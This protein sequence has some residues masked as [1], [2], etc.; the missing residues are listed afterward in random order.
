MND[1]LV[2]N[3][4]EELAELIINKGNPLVN[5][6]PETT[7]DDGTVSVIL[8]TEE[9][10]KTTENLNNEANKKEIAEVQEP[11]KKTRAKIS[12]AKK[13]LTKTQKLRRSRKNTPGPS[14]GKRRVTAAEKMHVFE[15]ILAGK[16]GYKMAEEL[17]RSE[18]TIGKIIEELREF[19][20]A[21]MVADD[22][23][24]DGYVTCINYENT[25]GF[26][27]VVTKLSQTGLSRDIAAK[28]AQKVLNSAGANN[29][30]VVSE[31]ELFRVAKNTVSGT[32]IFTSKTDGGQSVAIMN[33][34][35]SERGDLA[36]RKKPSSDIKDHIDNNRIFK[37]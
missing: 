33:K 21:A 37:I 19:A 13:P 5:Q 35:A 18:P 9:E 27:R 23:L 32:E 20:S 14:K 34:A 25:D 16:S 29:V 6:K 24:T 17:N 30:E 10:L 12:A 8:N 36:S 15:G 22:G 3:Y 11:A 1:D 26:N 2:S 31:R 4:D 7:N 28:R